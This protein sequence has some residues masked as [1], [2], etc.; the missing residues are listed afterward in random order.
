MAQTRYSERY[1]WPSNPTTKSFYLCKRRQ[2]VLTHGPKEPPPDISE[3][4]YCRVRG[5]GLAQKSPIEGGNKVH[6]F[7]GMTPRLQTVPNVPFRFPEYGMTNAS[8]FRWRI[9]SKGCEK[10]DIYLRE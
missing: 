7:M 9:P 10:G 3:M 8:N 1:I 2:K 5:G 6:L 4:P